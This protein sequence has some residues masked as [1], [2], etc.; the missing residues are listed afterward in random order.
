MSLQKLEGF[1]SQM[2]LKVNRS[3][4]D[5]LCLKD[6]DVDINTSCSSIPGRSNVLRPENALFMRILDL[7]SMITMD[8]L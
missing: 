6:F 8:F 4:K 2:T 3:R 7:K 5:K 1:V